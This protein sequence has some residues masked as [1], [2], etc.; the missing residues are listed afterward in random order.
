MTVLS[1]LFF[2]LKIFIL[3]ILCVCVHVRAYSCIGR[4]EENLWELVLPI[5]WIL[6]TKF[7]LSWWQALSPT[8]PSCWPDTDYSLANSQHVLFFRGQ[9]LSKKH[10]VPASFIKVN[11]TASTFEKNNNNKKTKTS[12]FLYF[13][14]KFQVVH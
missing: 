12:Q 5:M 9:L 13:A 1:K 7:R 4:S 8:E 10:N 11:H 14:I 3:C 6:G 2:H